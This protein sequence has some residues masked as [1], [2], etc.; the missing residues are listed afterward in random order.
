MQLRDR[1]QQQYLASTYFL[2]SDI[3]RKKPD[4]AFQKIAYLVGS[5][6]LLPSN[7]AKKARANPRGNQFLAS[8]LSIGIFASIVGAG[9]Y[10]YFSDT[11][12]STGNTMTAGVLD[13][14]VN[15]Q[16][17]MI[18]TLGVSNLKPN[19]TN[20]TDPF[21]LRIVDNPGRLCMRIDNIVCGQGNQTPMEIA[22][23]N[24]VPKFD[25]ANY[26]WFDINIAGSQK[27]IDGTVTVAGIE[28][29]WQCFGVYPRLT[30]LPI[31]QSFHLFDTVTAWAHGDDCNFTETFMVLQDN[32]PAPA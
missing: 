3:D 22:A 16:D 9:T 5:F 32:A 29:S 10:A 25:L 12:T 7:L 11:E 27:I 14:W 24:G 19:Q 20:Y 31:V 23:E 30:D 2:S 21:T 17:T 26:T 1:S 8:L 6:Y 13:L 4:S 15:G 18:L 28:G